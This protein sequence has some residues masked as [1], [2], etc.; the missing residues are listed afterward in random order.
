MPRRRI[1]PAALAWLVRHTFRYAEAAGLN[2]E[3]LFE[4]AG[5]P[6]ASASSPE[7]RL[8][9]RDQTRLL[10]AV[11]EAL[12]DPQLGF[13]LALDFDLRE[14]GSIYYVLASAPTLREALAS[15]ART[16]SPFE[17]GF[18][19]IPRTDTGIGLGFQF[20]GVENRLDRQLAE[21]TVTAHLRLFRH[22]TR[23]EL[24]PDRVTFIHRQERD[25]EE[26]ER[27]FRMAPTFGAIEHQI[28][29]DRD[30]AGLPVVTSDPFLGKLIVELRDGISGPPPK[31]PFRAKV[32]TAL[33]AALGQGPI[34]MD[35]LAAE[36]GL[37][38]RTLARRLAE[39]GETFA[40]ILDRVR[41]ELALQYLR[42]T[43]LPIS[44]IGWLL[45][46]ARPSACVRA[47]RRWTGTTPMAIRRSGTAAA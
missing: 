16:A 2:T 43:K 31:E 26:I 15:E 12:G 7:Q 20:A 24:V 34:H 47:V 5:L 36:V 33:T 38:R 23:R 22:L 35:D 25:I 46:Y 9:L 8:P 39:E 11:A 14:W 30:A 6:P 21:F 37:S 18:R 44:G 1:H 41:H 32:E 40:T 29:F 17:E 13:H 3:R 28:V 45:G 19:A 42:K 10:N 4:E 27:F